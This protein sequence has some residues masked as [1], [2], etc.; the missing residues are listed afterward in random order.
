M[1]GWMEDRVCLVTDAR[2]AEGEALAVA[3]AKMDAVVVVVARSVGEAEAQCARIRAA[4]GGKVEGVVGDLGSE[5]GVVELATDVVSAHD[6]LD[7][8]VVDAAVAPPRT[9]QLTESLVALLKPEAPVRVV[10]VVAGEAGASAARVLARRTAGSP[11]TVNAVVAETGWWAS[12]RRKAMGPLYVA[13]SPM[14]EGLTG[15]VFAGLR[16]VRKPLKPIKTFAK[17]S[18]TSLAESL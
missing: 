1:H 3:L 10:A 15:R 8:V 5:E 6:R 4:A 16:E 2:S 11:V 9:M 13:T 12:G 14:V 17:V 18:D 7:V